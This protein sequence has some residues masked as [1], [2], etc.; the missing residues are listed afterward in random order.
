VDQPLGKAP[1]CGR[2]LEVVLVLG[3]IFGYRDQLSSDLIP[4]FEHGFDAL[5]AGLGAVF[6][7]SCVCPGA[8]KKRPKRKP[9]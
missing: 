3:E 9:R 8:T 4:L 6:G 1:D 2:R 7:I 5:G